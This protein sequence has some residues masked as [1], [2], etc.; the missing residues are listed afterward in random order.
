MQQCTESDSFRLFFFSFVSFMSF[1]SFVSFFFV[2]FFSFLPTGTVCEGCS[3]T[4]KLQIENSGD[5]GASFKWDNTAFL[6]NFSVAPTDGFLA[7][8]A[9][10]VVDVTFHPTRV[11]DDFR[12]DR[13]MCMVEGR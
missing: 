6:P 4:R 2:S 9:S 3:V 11:F 12:C 8:H 13:L 5:L 7:P 10:V 1:V